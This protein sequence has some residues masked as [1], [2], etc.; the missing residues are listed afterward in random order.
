MEGLKDL[1]RG[2]ERPEAAG[3]PKIGQPQ[4]KAVFK[5]L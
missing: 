3:V 4:D 5:D 2:R 1:N